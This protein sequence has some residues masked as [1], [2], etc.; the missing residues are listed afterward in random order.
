MPAATLYADRVRETTTT[1]GTGSVTL[2]GAAAG[3]V[4]FN[5][6]YGTG[7]DF[8]YVIAGGAEWEVGRGSLSDATTLA[9]TEVLASSN[10]GAAVDFSAGEKDVFSSVPAA[11][12]NAIASRDERRHDVDG[13]FAYAGVAPAGSAEG[14]AVW[15]ITR[16]TISGA[17]TV[18]ATET[19]SGVEWD[20]R[21]TETYA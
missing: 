16:L 1:T 14:D 20:D 6:A 2:A 17:G 5:D 12:I 19:A 21:L 18:T 7:T 15:T 3:F 8:N 10:A 13:G 4:T 9:R 11:A